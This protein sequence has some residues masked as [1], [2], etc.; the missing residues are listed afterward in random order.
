MF[1]GKSGLLPFLFWPF[2][3]YLPSSSDSLYKSSLY[4]IVWWRVYSLVCFLALEET[5]AVSLSDIISTY[6]LSL[7]YKR[8]KVLY[9]ILACSRDWLSQNSSFSQEG[10]ECLQREGE[11]VLK[12]PWQLTFSLQSCVPQPFTSQVLCPHPRSLESSVR[13]NPSVPP[14][15]DSSLFSWR[16]L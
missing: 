2:C 3:A 1:F 15:Q 10:S 5:Q 4:Q 6:L 8:W 7:T 9:G 12:W 13:L 16:N 11:K 14:C